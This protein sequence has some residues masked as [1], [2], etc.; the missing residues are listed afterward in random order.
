M[1]SA[2]CRSHRHL[3]Q[4]PV[5]EA[6]RHRRGLTPHGPLTARELLLFPSSSWNPDPGGYI[7]TG[8]S[9]MS[10]ALSHSTAQM[11]RQRM[12]M[13]AQQTMTASQP[14]PAQVGDLLLVL[15]DEAQVAVAHCVISP[16]V[17]ELGDDTP[18]RPFTLYVGEDRRILFRRPPVLATLALSDR[19]FGMRK[20]LLRWGL[21]DERNRSEIHSCP[22]RQRLHWIRG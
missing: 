21:W 9:P 11:D 4:C 19:S 12:Q 13:F 15:L 2:H 6:H 3:P 17:E 5:S 16:P 14:T 8:V 7:V 10:P 1:R 18:P 22:Y 20:G